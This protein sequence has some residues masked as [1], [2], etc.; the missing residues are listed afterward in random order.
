MNK[1][2]IKI[3]K[4]QKKELAENPQIVVNSSKGES[5]IQLRIVSI[6]RNW[7]SERRENSRVEKVFSDSKISAWKNTCKNAPEIIG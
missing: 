5:N 7:I 3:V 4:R 2:V 6:V 1:A